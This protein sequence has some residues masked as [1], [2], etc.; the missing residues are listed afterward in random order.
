MTGGEVEP[1]CALVRVRDASSAAAARAE[2]RRV[3]GALAWPAETGEELAICA[4]ELAMN[5]VDHGG[6]CGS[7]A[8]VAASDGAFV[9]V[10]AHD[11][12]PGLDPG[13]VGVPS[14]PGRG[15][16]LPAVGRLMDVTTLTCGDGLLVW[17]RRWGDAGRRRAPVRAAIVQRP[18]RGERASGDAAMIERRGG[19]TRLAVIDGLGHGPPATEAAVVCVRALTD[20]LDAPLEAA[21]RAAHG[22]LA[23]TRGVALAVADVDEARRKAEVAVVGNCRLEVLWPEGRRSVVGLPGVLGHG[24]PGGGRW[25]PRVEPLDL[26]PGAVFAL[27]SDGISSRARFA[28]APRRDQVVP[29]ACR[30]FAAHASTNDDA[31]LLLAALE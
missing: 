30:V 10:G 19:R 8:V 5:V 22:A 3:A 17:G 7:V 12:G 27:A 11:R 23:A 6:A 29:E 14:A 13:R 4:S 24:R 28:T 1:V 21:V 26:P 31:T 2:A 18:R 20:A 15:G 9:E 25:S 16:G